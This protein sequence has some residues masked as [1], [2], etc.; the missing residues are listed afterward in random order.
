MSKGIRSV[1]RK[2]NTSVGCRLASTSSESSKR[3]PII[4][5]VFVRWLRL[6]DR[7]SIQAP[8]QTSQ[9]GLDNQGAY[10]SPTGPHPHIGWSR[11]TGRCARSRAKPIPNSAS[12][13]IAGSACREGGR[14]GLRSRCTVQHVVSVSTDPGV[15]H[16]GRHSRPVENRDSKVL[17]A[18]CGSQTVAI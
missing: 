16:A 11:T 2:R 5:N 9:M 4:A 14:E 15:C 1:A 3:I 18:D 13:L 7:R 10:R 12:T 8:F 6:D 17:V